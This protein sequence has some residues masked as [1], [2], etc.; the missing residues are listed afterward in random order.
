MSQGRSLVG[1]ARK[2]DGRV[3]VE[4]RHGTITVPASDVTSVV[5]GR[6]ALHEYRERLAALGSSPDAPQVYALSTWAR[7]Q[8]LI[9]YVAALQQ[10]TIALDPNHR[11]A[12]A[13]LDY[14]QYQGRWVPQQERNAYETGRRTQV[15][16]QQPRPTTTAK[17][18]PRPLPEMSPGYVYLGIPPSLPPRGSQNHDTGGMY[19]AIPFTTPVG[20]R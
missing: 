16:K 11:Q 6:T 9:R 7:E 1:I 19:I 18:R 2:E 8:G 3:V 15:E 20:I 5:P 10:W 17:V 14:V 4:T 13:D 12:R